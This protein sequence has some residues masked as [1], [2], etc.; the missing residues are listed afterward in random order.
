[1]PKIERARFGRHDLDGG[2]LIIDADADTY[3]EATVDDRIDLFIGGIDQLRWTDGL[4]Q[5]QKAYTIE[6]TAGA[7]TARAV[8]RLAVRATGLEYQRVSDAAV[9]SDQFPST[10][11]SSA[12]VWSI[13]GASGV[14]LGG[15]SGPYS[16]LANTTTA[17]FL[18]DCTFADA[19]NII[20]NATTGTKIGTATTQKLAF[21]NS[22]PVVQGVAVAD[23][24]GGAT[25][26][27]EART[28]I[29][30]LLARI[31]VFGLIAT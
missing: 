10:V 4:M 12:N 11:D 20:F 26:D 28:A 14:A 15:T 3:L 24:S 29:N 6:V 7:L 25:I 17:K 16:F 9:L 8:G 19:V 1:M 5:F 30:T 13:G 21:F 23:A 2:R 31:R 22:T 18:L 27:A